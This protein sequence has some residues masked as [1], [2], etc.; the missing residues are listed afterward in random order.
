MYAFQIYYFFFVSGSSDY[1]K[2]LEKNVL[3]SKLP[4]SHNVVTVPDV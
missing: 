3:S 1:L 2:S 4:T